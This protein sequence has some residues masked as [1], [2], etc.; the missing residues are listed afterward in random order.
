MNSKGWETVLAI[1]AERD[2]LR[3]QR[4]AALEILRLLS[5]RLSFH[6]LV[7]RSRHGTGDVLFEFPHE[8]YEAWK[9]ISPLLGPT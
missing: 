1:Q 8:A 9:A 3:V 4:D 7:L 5:P 6:G 2:E